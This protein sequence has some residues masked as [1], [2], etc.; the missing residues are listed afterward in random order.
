MMEWQHI[1]SAP[2]D[3]TWIIA[4]DGK[5]VQPVCWAEGYPDE[6]NG[7]AYGSAYWG[8]TLYEGVNEVSEHPTHWMPLPPPPTGEKI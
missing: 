3:G 4:W 1:E 8:G 5:S 7:W 6:Y 2:R